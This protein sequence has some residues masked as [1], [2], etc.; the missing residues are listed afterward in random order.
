[1]E[2]FLEVL[3]LN[4]RMQECQSIIRDSNLLRLEQIL[5]NLTG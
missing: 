1:M 4:P 2:P 3:D 5:D